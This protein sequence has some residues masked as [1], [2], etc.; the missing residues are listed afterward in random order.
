MALSWS[1]LHKGIQKTSSKLALLPTGQKY[2][3][4]ISLELSKSFPS[5]CFEQED[6]LLELN[7]AQGRAQDLPCSSLVVSPNLGRVEQERDPQYFWGKESIS[8]P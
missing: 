6:D 3:K 5:S 4:M 2:L 8:L 1:F 7:P